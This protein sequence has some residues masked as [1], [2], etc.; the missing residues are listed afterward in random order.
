MRG[1]VGYVGEN[2]SV[3][4]LMDGLYFLEYRIEYWKRIYEMGYAWS[5][6]RH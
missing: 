4:I 5:A 3:D 2:N 1:V 6:F